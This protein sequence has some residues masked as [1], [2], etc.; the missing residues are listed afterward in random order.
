MVVAHPIIDEKPFTYGYFDIPRL[1]RLGYEEEDL[2]SVKKI[3]N[4]IPEDKECAY[5][6][7]SSSKEALKNNPWLHALPSAEEVK[8]LTKEEAWEHIDKALKSCNRDFDEGFTAV[9]GGKGV[10]MTYYI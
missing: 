2:E 10:F 9:C 3:L 8:Y 7:Y 5:F 6:S 4:S 1:K